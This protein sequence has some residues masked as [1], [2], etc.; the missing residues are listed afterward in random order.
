MTTISNIK[1]PTDQ[2]M[3]PRNIIAPLLAVTLGIFMVIL[4]STAVNVILPRL[5][6]EF[7]STLSVI[8]W[9]VTGYTLALS[10]VIPLAGW[11]S[12]RFGA[13]RVFL[14]SVALFTLGSVLCSLAITPE[15]IIA[16]RVIQGLGGGMVA[17]IAMALTYKLSPPEKVG[18][19][20]AM[21]GI[22]MLIAP[23]L[24]PVLAGW[25]ADYVSWQWVFLINLPIGIIAILFGL[26]VL[27]NSEPTKRLALDMAGML[28]APIAFASL[29]YGISEGGSSW[30][31]MRTLTGLL[32]GIIGLMIFIYVELRH[33][34]PLLD[35]R[36]FFL[37]DFRK[38]IAVLW[39]YQIAMGAVFFI[40]PIFLQQIQ[41]Y[42]SFRAGLIMLPMAVSSAVFMQI[43]GRLFDKR[44][45]RLVAISGLGFVTLGVFLFSQIPASSGSSMIILPLVFVGAG[46]GSSMMPLNAHVIQT[47]PPDKVEH[48]TS[49]TNAMQQVMSSF[50]VTGVT[51]ILALRTA[52]YTREAANPLSV[53]VSSYGD[54]FLVIAAIALC[55]VLASLLLTK[56][57]MFKN[58]TEKPE[59]SAMT[60]L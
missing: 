26:R 36:I 21:L 47:A 15:Q 45:V 33:K 34:Q 9:A 8:Q 42:S 6:K 43:G 10:A 18:M 14:V 23:A 48:V 20:M 51:S 22:P 44:G 1:A 5:T 3:L 53:G 38:G 60:V 31:S 58:E 49:L 35:L 59:P 25:L 13:K 28:L 37:Q 27:P 24:G 11:M 17:P 30:T 41:G 54:T 50:A 16:F 52:Y 4:D 12:K 39:I 56:S 7:N 57:N 19:I 40:V 2:S 32:V 55:A 46:M 29:A